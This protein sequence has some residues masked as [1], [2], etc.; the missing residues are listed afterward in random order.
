M[1]EF[2]SHPACVI[3]SAA[4]RATHIGRFLRVRYS[5]PKAPALAVLVLAIETLVS[6]QA[7]PPAEARIFVKTANIHDFAPVQYTYVVDQNSPQDK[8]P[9]H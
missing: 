2:S 9:D 3:E 1:G 7:V 8:T 5:I 4:F 6:A